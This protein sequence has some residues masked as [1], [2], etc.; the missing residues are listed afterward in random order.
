MAL[1]VKNINCVIL[2]VQLAVDIINLLKFLLCHEQ[3][4]SSIHLLHPMKS[5]TIFLWNKRAEKLIFWHSKLEGIRSRPEKVST[6]YLIKNQVFSSTTLL[7]FRD[8]RQKR[9][10]SRKIAICRVSETPIRAF[11]SKIWFFQST[12]KKVYFVIVKVLESPTCVLTPPGPLQIGSKT[13]LRPWLKPLFISE[14]KFRVQ[15][16]SNNLNVI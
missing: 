4:R 7:L 10:N 1:A 16:V 13:E 8:F 12:A 5:L 11:F 9:K 14:K 15:G 6:S 2:S 3:W